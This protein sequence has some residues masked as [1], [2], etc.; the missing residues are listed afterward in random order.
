LAGRRRRDREHWEQVVELS[1]VV[2][3][4]IP[5]SGIL[6]LAELL[7]RDGLVAGTLLLGVFSVPPVLALWL[8]ERRR[9]RA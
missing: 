7:W 1:A 2:M 9:R 3:L 4:L 6:F 8:I 5:T